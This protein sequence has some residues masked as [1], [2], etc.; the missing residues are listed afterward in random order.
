[1]R[2]KK[3]HVQEKAGSVGNEMRE[4]G[5]AKLNLAPSILKAPPIIRWCALR[6][7]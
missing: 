7:Q 2:Q 6:R 5:P 3:W 4:E 1:M